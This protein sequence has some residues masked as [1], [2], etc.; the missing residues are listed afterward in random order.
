MTAPD[1]LQP[2]APDS[3]RAGGMSFPPPLIQARLSETFLEFP[4]EAQAALASRDRALAK[5]IARAG[6][7]RRRIYPDP[8]TGLARSILSQQISSKARDAIWQRL[9]QKFAPIH[10]RDFAKL[11]LEEIAACGVSRRKAQCLLGIAAAF[12]AGEL[13]A[14][15]LAAMD[16]EEM[17]NKLAALPGIGRWTAEMLLIFTFQRPN[18]LSFTDGGL[19]RAIRKLYGYDLTRARHN[20]LCQ[21]YSPYC[22]LASF[23]LWEVA[24]AEI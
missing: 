2:A 13:D 15:K 24:G 19:R 6:S 10:A 11:D 20:E 9:A 23:Y 8:F 3:A 17:I 14:E 7:L 21:L 16:D 12:A 5:V 1:K 22:T 18:V 4:Q